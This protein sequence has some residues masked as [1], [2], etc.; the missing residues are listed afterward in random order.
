M[1]VT[2]SKLTTVIRVKDI[3]L[4]RQQK[5]LA[6]IRTQHEEASGVLKDLEDTRD[7]AYVDAV[8]TP[9]T[10]A[11][12]VQ[13][14]EAFIRSLSRQIRQ[15]EQTVTDIGKAEEVKCDEVTKVSQS[16]R[17]LEQIEVRRKEE[18]DKE[19]ERK[20]QRLIDVLAQRLHSTT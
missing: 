15:Q 9:K 12:D 2:Q 7:Q 8:K 18:A 19:I 17:M 1:E 11:V 13:T 14:S 10:K 20:A 4:K 3:L 16:K 5:E 6:D